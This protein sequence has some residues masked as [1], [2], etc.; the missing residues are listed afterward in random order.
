MFVVKLKFPRSNLIIPSLL[1]MLI[2]FVFVSRTMAK[3]VWGLVQDGLFLACE[4]SSFEQLQ[5]LSGEFQK[6]YGVQKVSKGTVKEG[7]KA[8][9]SFPEGLLSLESIKLE[10]GSGRLVIQFFEHLTHKPR[11]FVLAGAGCRVKTVRRLDYNDDGV[12]ERLNYLDS[13]FKQVRFIDELNPPIPEGPLVNGIRVAVVDSGINYMLPA[14]NY[15]LGRRSDGSV[16]GYDFWD[17]DEHPFDYIPIPSPFFP[18]RHGTK[19]SSVIVRASS[20]AVI[21]PYRYPRFEMARMG[22]LVRHA[23]VNGARIVNVSLAGSDLESWKIFGQ[24]IEKYSDILFVLAA[25]NDE[26]DIDQEPVYPAAFSSDNTVVVTGAT[27]AGYLAPGA[28]WGM[29]SVDLLVPSDHVR[30]L[31]FD[32]RERWVGGSSYAA[33][34][35]SGLAACLLAKEP[36]LNVV[37]LRKELFGRA[38]RINGGH[39]VRHGFLREKEFAKGDDC[40]RDSGKGK[41]SHQL[42]D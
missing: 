7:W 10:G 3:E 34:R 8:E 2:I 20:A 19:I 4:S 33:A 22:D 14:L 28:N 21:L 15:R 24:S 6:T 39:L 29:K 5:A 40:G 13:S 31:G 42:G 36:N 38:D 37:N 27:A 32:G 17:L 35:V 1:V 23:A 30:V 25:G 9:F 16:V 41:S 18:S 11:W 12:A 26:R